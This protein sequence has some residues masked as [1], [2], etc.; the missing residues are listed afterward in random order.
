MLHLRQFQGKVPDEGVVWEGRD[1]WTKNLQLFLTIVSAEGINRWNQ[2]GGTKL[3]VM[4]MLEDDAL[5]ENSGR[6]KGRDRG[7]PLLIEG[8]WVWHKG[9]VSEQSN[10]DSRRKKHLLKKEDILNV[11]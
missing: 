6:V 8:W 10:Y 4:E 3:E 9:D 11:L 1:E 2:D 7:K 5:E